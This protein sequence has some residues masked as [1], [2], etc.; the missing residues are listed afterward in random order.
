MN[1]CLSG[2]RMLLTSAN[3]APVGI[4]ARQMPKNSRLRC[5]P[6]SSEGRAIGQLPGEEPQQV[7]GSDWSAE[8]GD[9]PQSGEIAP[10]AYAREPDR[11]MFNRSPSA[12][13]VRT[14]IRIAAPGKRASQ[15][16]VVIVAC[17]WYS[18]FPQLAVGG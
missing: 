6:A 1:S 14:E 13:T 9:R 2:T 15:G 8:M 17:A 11:R 16:S 10:T 7:Y 12:L 18:M 4:S 3:D 5:T